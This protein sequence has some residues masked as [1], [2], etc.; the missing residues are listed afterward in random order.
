VPDAPIN[1]LTSILRVTVLVNLFLLLSEIFTHFYTGGH[2]AISSEY[3][4]FGLG[5]ANALVPWIWS[6]IALN[7][8]AAA[9]LLFGRESTGHMRRRWLLLACVMT[10]AGVWIEKGMGLII[11]AFVPSTLGEIVEYTPSLT[12]WKITAGIW[13]FGMGLL[14]I[15]I[16]VM[17]Y[18][19]H[20]GKEQ[21]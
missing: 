14:T 1:T 4:L 15:A 9:I 19:F 16:R 18:M 12:E 3:L 2:H 7:V 8:G 20:Q 10:F 5:D 11:P 13:A 17:S 21:E 6:G